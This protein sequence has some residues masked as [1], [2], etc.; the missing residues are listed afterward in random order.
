ME[1]V[2]TFDPCRHA[3]ESEEGVGRISGASEERS[4]SR[5]SSWSQRPATK[6]KYIS[7]YQKLV[8]LCLC[9]V[10]GPEELWQRL[11]VHGLVDTPL[12][13][14]VPS[15]EDLLEFIVPPPPEEDYVVLPPCV[16]LDSVL[17]PE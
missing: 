3:S 7:H 13:F 2:V 4:S 12:S 8:F 1:Y 10:I 17:H 9:C 11:E 15:P 16:C 5:R 14:Q 6:P